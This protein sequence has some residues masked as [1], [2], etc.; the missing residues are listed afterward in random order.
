MSDGWMGSEPTLFLSLA[1]L[2]C[3]ALSLRGG[4]TCRTAFNS[5]SGGGRLL[6]A[7][8]HDVR[9]YGYGTTPYD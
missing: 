3:R 7:D 6:A 8:L 9:M 4:A 1:P 2:A 5:L